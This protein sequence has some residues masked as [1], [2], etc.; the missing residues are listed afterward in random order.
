TANLQTGHA[1]LRGD[2]DL[3]GDGGSGIFGD[4]DVTR[5]HAVVIRYILHRRAIGTAVDSDGDAGVGLLAVCI[6]HLVSEGLGQC[7]KVV[8]GIDCRVGV[9][10]HIGVGAVGIGG[11]AAVLAGGAGPTIEGDRAVKGAVVSQ[12]ITADGVRTAVFDQGMRFVLGHGVGVGD[13]YV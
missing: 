8:Q 11:E 4:A 1:G 10:Q 5:C 12:G 9:V 2:G 13:Q 6:A 7:L 3:T